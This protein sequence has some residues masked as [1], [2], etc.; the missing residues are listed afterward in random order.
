MRAFVADVTALGSRPKRTG[1]VRSIEYSH[2]AI[3][4]F[5]DFRVIQ[6]NGRFCEHYILGS[7]DVKQYDINVNVLDTENCPSLLMIAA[8]QSLF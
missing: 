5:V 2:R 7:P 3:N 6:A 8:W 4:Q 1:S